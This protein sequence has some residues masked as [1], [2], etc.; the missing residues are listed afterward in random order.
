MVAS[1]QQQM[2]Q[3]V[4]PFTTF[5]LNYINSPI[6]GLL[7]LVYIRNLLS[8][9]PPPPWKII[10]IIYIKSP[11]A[12]HWTE[13]R[14]QNIL[15]TLPLLHDLSLSLSVVHSIRDKDKS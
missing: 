8:S 5:N 2:A 15:N 6:H 1:K 13:E 4:L 10:L 9:P 11:H 14:V 7:C 12:S 3:H